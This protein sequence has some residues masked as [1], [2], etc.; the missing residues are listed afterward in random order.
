LYNSN[1]DGA[2]IETR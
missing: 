2:G 1:L